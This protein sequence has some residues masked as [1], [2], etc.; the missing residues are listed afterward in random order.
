MHCVDLQI[1]LNSQAIHLQKDHYDFFEVMMNIF[2]FFSRC[3]ST[4]WIQ[5][6]F[7][8]TL[9]PVNH[10][11]ASFI[12]K[13]YRMRLRLISSQ[14]GVSPCVTYNNYLIVRICT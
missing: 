14:I 13:N 11:V 10:R 6:T 5:F 2:P 9:K 8:N 1:C 4:V 7:E 12:L 3:L